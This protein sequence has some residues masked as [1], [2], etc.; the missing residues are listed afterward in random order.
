MFWALMRL[1]TRI[2]TR[3]LWSPIK[4][5]GVMAHPW[6]MPPLQFYQL[7]K[8]LQIPKEEILQVVS[9]STLSFIAC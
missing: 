2:E 3:T 8:M 5:S 7:C 4:V 9:T 1:I 6:P